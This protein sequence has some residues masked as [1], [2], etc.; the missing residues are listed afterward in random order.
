MFRLSLRFF[1][2][3]GI[4]VSTILENPTLAGTNLAYAEGERVVGEADGDE[5]VWA[6][7]RGSRQVLHIHER[8]HGNGVKPERN[9]F[10]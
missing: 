9:L 3:L 6:K 1:W 2:P 5:R 10:F 4:R 7:E 8:K